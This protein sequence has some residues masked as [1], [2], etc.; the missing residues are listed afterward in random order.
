MALESYLQSPD[1]ADTND[2]PDIY[3]VDQDSQRG[4]PNGTS[5]YLLLQRFV[6]EMI[7]GGE[8]RGY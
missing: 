1:A 2:N 7:L 5:G 4:P 8:K 6:R 3:V